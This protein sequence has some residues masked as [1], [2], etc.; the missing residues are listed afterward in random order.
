MDAFALLASAAPL[1]PRCDLG[2]SVIPI[3]TRPPTL[4]AMAATTLQTFSPDRSVYLGV[5]ASSRSIVEGWHGL[6][7]PRSPLRAVREY[8]DIARRCF[9]GE[10]VDFHGEFFEVQGFRADVR[11]L[12]DRRPLI[13]V[14][15]LNPGMLQLAGQV[16]DAV[17]LNSVAPSWIAHARADVLRY[18][19]DVEMTAFV[20]VGV[21]DRDR[22]LG[23]LR[24]SVISEIT[25]PGY[26]RLLTAMGYAG[27][28]EAAL[29][30]MRSRDFDAAMRVIPDE[31]IDQL[32]A[33]GDSGTVTE[34]VRAARAAGLDHVIVFPEIDDIDELPPTLAGVAAGLEPV[35]AQSGAAGEPLD[36]GRQSE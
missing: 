1:A 7:Y 6:G 20:H 32:F 34:H 15:A 35:N 8:V 13:A 2:T 28:V 36:Q 16:A 31:L 22:A 29:S 27:P 18:G 25:E 10:T 30:A 23:R 14:A 26:A 5:G 12:A 33:I 21:S 11:G 24:H 9:N 17:V 19:R 3:G 4:A